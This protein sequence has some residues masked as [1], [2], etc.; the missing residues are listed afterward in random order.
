MDKKEARSN[1]LRDR[2]K[3]DYVNRSKNVVKY[4]IDNNILDKFNNIGIYY[5]IGTEINIMDLMKH[6]KNKN[7]YLPKTLDE[8]EFIKYDLND[9]LI[10]GPFNTK[11]P[12][13][14]SVNRDLID[15]YIIPCVA[16]SKNNQRI[17]Y[18]KGYYD[19]YLNGY[20]GYKIGICYKEYGDLDLELDK[21][22][23]YLDLKI[24]G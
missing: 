12:N 15:C 23:V 5:P 1:S 21:F 4:I 10:D 17:G 6:Y 11:E 3:V 7:F 2:R 18:G 24:L 14:N 9:K 19:R 13:G 16:I 8:I 20:K 22:D